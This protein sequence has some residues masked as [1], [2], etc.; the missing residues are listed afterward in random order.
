MQPTYHVSDPTESVPVW[1]WQ[2][3]TPEYHGY[4]ASTPDGMDARAA[5]ID[6]DISTGPGRWHSTWTGTEYNRTFHPIP[7]HG[8][9]TATARL[10]A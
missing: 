7:G 1:Y 4:W 9:A 6:G 5:I 8:R 2:A 10:S 3:E